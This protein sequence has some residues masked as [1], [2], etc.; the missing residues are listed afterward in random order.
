MKWKEGKIV[1]GQKHLK[2]MTQTPALLKWLPDV[3]VEVN[4]VRL[5]EECCRGMEGSNRSNVARWVAC[6]VGR[7]YR[8]VHTSSK[9]RKLIEV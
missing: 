4:E 6:L 1:G 9:G 2:R 8:P 3:D 5:C 7:S